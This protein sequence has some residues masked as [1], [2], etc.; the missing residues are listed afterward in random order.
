MTG[1]Q[2]FFRGKGVVEED[3]ENP[4]QGGGGAAGVRIIL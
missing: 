4:Q 2:E 1:G 3:K